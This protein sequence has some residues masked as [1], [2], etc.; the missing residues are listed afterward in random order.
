MPITNLSDQLRRDEEERQFAYDDAT[1]KTLLKGM[2][3]KA[4]LTAGVGRNLS[5]KGLSQ[6]ERDFLLA[7]DIQDSTVAL[8]GNFPWVMGLDEARKGALLNLTFNMGSHALSGWPKFMAAMKAGDWPT[9]KAEL[10]DSA[11]DH[12]EPQRISRLALQIDSGFWQ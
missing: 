12:Q 4:N 5:A 1:G 9:A 2:T 3:L 10:L 11:A 6:K 7:N 8:E